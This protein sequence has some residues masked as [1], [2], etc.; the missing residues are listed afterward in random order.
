MPA[1]RALVSRAESE[2]G[3]VLTRFARLHSG[4]MA[5]AVI[6]K[7]L[8]ERSFRREMEAIALVQEARNNVSDDARVQFSVTG[9]ARFRR[10][11]DSI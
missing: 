10:F 3:R 7:R 9:A 11:D 6:W 1:R 5:I 4:K 8:G 2:F